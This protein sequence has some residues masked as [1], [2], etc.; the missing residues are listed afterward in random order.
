MSKKVL[1]SSRKS[2]EASGLE[3]RLEQVRRAAPPHFLNAQYRWFRKSYRLC[4]SLTKQDRKELRQLHKRSGGVVPQKGDKA[5]RMIIDLTARK[6]VK[7]K[8]KL[9]YATRLK[10]ARQANVRPKNLRGWIES[11]GGI[12][13]TAK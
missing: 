5:M 1:S 9:R 8:M 3:R 6:H 12:N 4:I 2:G 10:E 13:G 7:A 11:H